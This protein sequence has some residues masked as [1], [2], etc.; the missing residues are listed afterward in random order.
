[1]DL[2]RIPFAVT[3]WRAVPAVEQKG[4]SGTSFWRVT[5]AGGTRVRMADYSPGFRSDHWCPKG[6]VFLVIEGEFSVALKD[7]RVFRLSAGKSTRRDSRRSSG[8]QTTRTVTTSS[9]ISTSAGKAT[10]PGGRSAM[11]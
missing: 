11:A 4:E 1:M 2:G 9:T 6:H 8:R 3:D 10:P 7:G 5:E